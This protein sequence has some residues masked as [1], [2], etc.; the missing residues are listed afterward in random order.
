[1][2]HELGPAQYRKN[3]LTGF[4]AHRIV[5]EKGLKLI[6]GYFSISRKA[7]GNIAA[8]PPLDDAPKFLFGCDDRRGNH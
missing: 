5:R 2:K 8:L 1:M 7:L 3:A 6:P 4:A